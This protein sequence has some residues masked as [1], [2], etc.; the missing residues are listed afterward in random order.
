MAVV[1]PDHRAL[2]SYH[3][4]GSSHLI[5]VQRRCSASAHKA[6]RRSTRERDASD[7]QNSGEC[8]SP[9]RH[10]PIAGCSILLH[11]MCAEMRT[12]SHA[13][14]ARKSTLR[15]ALTLQGTPRVIPSCSR[16]H[17]RVQPLGR[18]R[19]NRS[20][21][22]TMGVVAYR[23]GSVTGSPVSFATVSIVRRAVS[24]SRS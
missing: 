6:A 12:A 8:T 20:M 21:A 9:E 23:T 10:H 13:E 15:A 18:S 17:K 11:G 14:P 19:W 16:A 24:S 1:R 3:R 2:P 7:V 22:S 4:G 5:L